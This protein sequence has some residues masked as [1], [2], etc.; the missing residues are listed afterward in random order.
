MRYWLP[1]LAALTG[2]AFEDNVEAVRKA[3]KK[4]A[5]DGYAYE[6]K[7]KYDRGGEWVPAGVLT[8]R[9]KLYQSVRYGEA[10]LVKG[11]EGLWK[12]PDER[13]GEK[14]QKGGDP[15][16]EPIVRLLQ[17]TEP[18]H[19]ILERALD[20]SDKVLDPADREVDGVQCRR[21]LIPIKKEPLKETLQKQME[22]AMKTGGLEGPDEVRWSTMKGTVAVYI[23]RDKGTL[24]KIKDERSVEI[25]Y[26]VPDSSPRVKKY[27]LEWDFDFSQTGQAKLTLPKEVKERLGIKEE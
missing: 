11:P 24:R 2:V 27:R 15:E 19:K 5:D 18:P 20:Q 8:S 22:K 9:I 14:V 23:V 12:T 16:A 10:I 3:I 1:W 21:F 7:G 6:V 13:I 26:K 17:E 4:T 25:A